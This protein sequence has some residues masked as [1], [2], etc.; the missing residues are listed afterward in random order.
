MR[1]TELSVFP[2]M[3]SELRALLIGQ[4]FENSGP[5][6]FL[7]FNALLFQSWYRL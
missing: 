2:K 4:E 1:E 7:D 3:P 5:L 6:F